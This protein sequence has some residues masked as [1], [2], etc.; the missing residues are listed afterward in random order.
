MALV[1][2]NI[3][4]DEILSSLGKL[5][6]RKMYDELADE[7]DASDGPR[8]EGKSLTPTESD[9]RKTLCDVWQHR[10]V[11]TPEQMSRISNILTE[12]FIQ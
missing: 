8:L 12:P 2:I 7:F 1:N 5:E 11:L 10:N 6:R 3:E 9:F 4:V